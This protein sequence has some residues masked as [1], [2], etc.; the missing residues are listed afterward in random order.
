MEG[1]KVKRFAT[2]QPSKFKVIALMA[3]KQQIDLFTGEPKYAMD[4]RLGSFNEPVNIAPFLE[5]V[6]VFRA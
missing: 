1:I 2:T 3:L 5:T 6:E 4:C